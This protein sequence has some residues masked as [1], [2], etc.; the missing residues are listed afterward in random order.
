[1]HVL[2]LQTVLLP[3]FKVTSNLYYALSFQKL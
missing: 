1:M 3:D 2:P